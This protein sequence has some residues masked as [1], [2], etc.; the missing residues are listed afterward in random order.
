MSLYHSFSGISFNQITRGFR[1]RVRI[2]RFVTA[3]VA[4]DPRTGADI[5]ASTAGTF[6]QWPFECAGGKV[7]TT[8]YAADN[9][10][11]S[12]TTFDPQ[13]GLLTSIGPKQPTGTAVVW[14]GNEGVFT[15][16]SRGNPDEYFE[17]IDGGTIS[18]FDKGVTVGISAADGHMGWKVDGEPCDF[19]QNTPDVCT[20]SGWGPDG[21]LQL[22]KASTS[23]A[24]L[25][26]ATGKPSWTLAVPNEWVGN[27]RGSSDIYFTG[28]DGQAINTKTDVTDP[29][30]GTMRP[31][32]DGER[33]V[34]SMDVYS[35]FDP[36]ALP[37]HTGYGRGGGADEPLLRPQSAAD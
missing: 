29:V 24:R 19:G 2:A 21:R 6:G 27:L 35:D 23:M 16:S 4:A 36:S 20:Y 14:G 33:S 13:T 25:D 22:D 15:V 28:V 26:P 37:S 3:L 30:S 10:S 12:L 17:F 8:L 5:A 18:E 9:A 34:C 31:A 7:C 1:R 32:K 11:Q